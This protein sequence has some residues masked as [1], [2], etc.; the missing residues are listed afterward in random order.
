MYVR[1]PAV[2]RGRSDLDAMAV[3]VRGQVCRVRALSKRL[4]FFDLH[5]SPDDGAEAARGDGAQHA[6]VLPTA[7]AERAEQWVEVMAKASEWDGVQE[8][9]DT[10]RC[11]A[12]H[13][14]VRLPIGS[15]P[16]AA[17]GHPPAHATRTNPLPNPGSVTW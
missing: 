12:H 6:G 2:N 4:V 5:C 14:G 9:R 16:T 8:A 3:T 17:C 7:A 11:A 15:P 10:I 1:E 13:P